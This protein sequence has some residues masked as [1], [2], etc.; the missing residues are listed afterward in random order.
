[1]YKYL[2]YEKFLYLSSSTV[3]HVRLGAGEDGHVALRQGAQGQPHH[4]TGQ[5][6][7][8]MEILE[9]IKIAHIL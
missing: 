3:V 8:G 2:F 4:G 7:P 9:I 5:P 1:M 6:I